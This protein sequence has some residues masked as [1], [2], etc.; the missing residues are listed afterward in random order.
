MWICFLH[1]LILLLIYSLRQD[2][3][4]YFLMQLEV[5]LHN[6]IL[7]MAC[8]KYLRVIL[9]GPQ[10]GGIGPQFGQNRGRNQKLG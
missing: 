2:L 10:T 1:C 7:H 9:K 4:P 6:K 8:E 5:T 3:V